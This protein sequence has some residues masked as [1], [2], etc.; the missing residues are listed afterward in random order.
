MPGCGNP[1]RARAA[2]QLSRTTFART[3]DVAS[4]KI[5]LYSGKNNAKEHYYAAENV[6]VVSY[7]TSRELNAV[8]LAGDVLVCRS[9]YSSIM[10]LAAAGKKAILIPTPGQ[11]EQEYL[12]DLFAR[13]NIFL[14]QRQDDIDLETGLEQVI[15]TTGL[16]PG[17]FAPEAFKSTLLHWLNDL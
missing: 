5:Y 13:K 6:E 17:Q 10:D 16:S 9:G 8:L 11:T 15:G 1:F 4:A 7:L 14:A 3:G 2:A 12:A